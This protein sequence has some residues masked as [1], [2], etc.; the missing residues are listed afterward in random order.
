[1]DRDKRLIALFIDDFNLWTEGSY[2]IAAWPDSEIR[3]RKAVDALARDALGRELAIE[4]TLL[5]PFT[6]EKADAVSFLKVAELLDRRADLAEPNWMIDLVF[7]VGAIPRGVDW[8]NV[9]QRLE[10]WFINVRPT[11]KAGRAT[12]E[13]GQLPFA[14][15]VTVDKS[16]MP[17]TPGCLFVARKMPNES[18]E[19]VI[20]GAL[21][22]KLPKLAATRAN[23]RILVLE[24]DSPV[25]GYWEVGQAIEDLRG[26]FPDVASLS[27]I[28]IARTVAWESEGYVGFHLIWPLHRVEQ[29]Q[30]WWRARPD[31]RLHPTAAAEKASGRG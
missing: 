27:S 10:D 20:Y 8:P 21:A 17:D 1:L 24:M 11:L 16:A 12:Y 6:G 25:R 26:K 30:E 14:L 7:D 19:P 4:H 13:V 28:W 18:I 29:H 15:I 31:K 2:A 9:A 23:E 5:Q 3:D 22:A